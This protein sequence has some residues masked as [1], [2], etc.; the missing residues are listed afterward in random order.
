MVKAIRE[1]GIS[2]ELF[3]ESGK[4]K[5]QLG[6][7]DNLG[8]PFVAMVGESEMIANVIALKNMK[9]GEQVSVTLAQLIAQLKGK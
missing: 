5:K 6:Y 8:I 1:A 4:M 7:A 2:A 9:T 3:P